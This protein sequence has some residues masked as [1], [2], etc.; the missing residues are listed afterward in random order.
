MK[1]FSYALTTNES[2]MID[3]CPKAVRFGPSTLYSHELR[4]AKTADIIQNINSTVEGV[5][6]EVPE[7][8]IDMITI[9]ENHEAKKQVLVSNGKD[10]I[11]AW[12]SKRKLY[13]PPGPPTWDYWERI[14]NSYDQQG[15]PTLQIIHAIDQLDNYYNT[16]FKFE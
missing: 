14:E 8:Y 13:V 3:I 6:W 9:I 5:L 15:L 1:Y 16:G 2:T 12:T 4:F 11:R 7:E 10:T